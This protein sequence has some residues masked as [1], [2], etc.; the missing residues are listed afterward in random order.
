MGDGRLW[1]VDCR[2]VFVCYWLLIVGFVLV[3]VCGL[4][5]CVRVCVCE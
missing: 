2:V 5:V 4:F 1:F 3:V